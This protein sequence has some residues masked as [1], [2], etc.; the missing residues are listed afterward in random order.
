MKNKKKGFLP[1][2]TPCFYKQEVQSKSKIELKVYLASRLVNHFNSFIRYLKNNPLRLW[3]HRRL[4]DLSN[5]LT[6]YHI[7]LVK[8]TFHRAK[9]LLLKKGNIFS[10]VFNHILFC[11]LKVAKRLSQMSLLGQGKKCKTNFKGQ[12]LQLKS[13]FS[14]LYNVCTEYL[15]TKSSGTSAMLL[16]I[17]T[18]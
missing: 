2:K 13:L 11:F 14:C 16:P 1:L 5:C 10:L 8:R 9:V 15:L 4:Q 3:S 12:L 18:S 7:A 17:F 6:K